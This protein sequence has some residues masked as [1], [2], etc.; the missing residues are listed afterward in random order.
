[1]RGKIVITVPGTRSTLNCETYT[2]FFRLCMSS[3][4]EIFRP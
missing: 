3:V 1:M 4:N 2:W